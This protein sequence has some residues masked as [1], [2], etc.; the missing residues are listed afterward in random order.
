MTK[1]YLGD[2]VYVDFDGW[3]I[4]LTTENG[5]TVTNRICLSDYT[6]QEFIRWYKRN[7]LKQEG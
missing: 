7:V 1:V 6:A 5:I 4:V 2:G 3:N